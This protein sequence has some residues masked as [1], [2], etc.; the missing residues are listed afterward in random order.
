M[1]KT[2][3]RWCY[4]EKRCPDST[5]CDRIQ[6][7]SLF[8]QRGPTPWE[9]EAMTIAGT[10]SKHITLQNHHLSRLKCQRSSLVFIRGTK[11]NCDL[12]AAQFQKPLTTADEM[13]TT[14][15]QQPPSHL[16]S[17]IRIWKHDFCRTISSGRLKLGEACHCYWM[18][19][20]W[21]SFDNFWEVNERQ[22]AS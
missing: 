11:G 5:W 1:T 15:L 22:V 4:L 7:L 20:A 18:L 19:V 21:L 16:N 9:K 13:K 14:F 8:N 12:P 17:A 3:S 6:L 2:L 10:S